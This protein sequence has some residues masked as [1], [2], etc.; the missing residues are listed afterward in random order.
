[1]H[2]SQRP[3]TKRKEVYRLNAFEALFSAAWSNKI[4]P[5]L[6]FRIAVGTILDGN[7]FQNNKI[8]IVELDDSIGDLV[9]RTSLHHGY[10]T[11]SLK[12]IPTTD[13]SYPELL[14]SISSNLKIHKYDT[15]THK[16]I[17]EC[18]LISKNSTY[19]SPF[20]GLDWNELHPD[21][22]ATSS[23]DSTCTVWNIEVGKELSS[24]SSVKGTINRQLI[25]H[26][27]PVH[28]IAFTRLGNG[29]DQ[30]ATAGFDGSIRMFDL[31]QLQHSTILYEHSESRPL[32]KLSFNKQFP[33]MLAAIPDDSDKVIIL[34]TRKPCETL[35]TL[36][37]HRETINGISWAPH[38]SRH[39]ATG[40]DKN[41][42]IWDVMNPDDPLLAYK[43]E[44]EISQ[45]QWASS[46]TEWICICFLKHL[47]ILR[48]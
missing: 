31:R 20:T 17:K 33:T 36:G 43:A 6:I 45:I 1:M 12:F 47:E 41:A 42:L 44:A 3:P 15:S 27:K 5:N 18:E 38:S 39:I 35:T 28:D 25:A 21:L 29:R 22:I 2:Q 40:N 7:D 34:D 10:P 11:S 24:C 23:I 26:E 4:Y 48:A 19:S 9:I 14:A 32:N 37:K 30:F 46:F 16:L 8:Y 13:T